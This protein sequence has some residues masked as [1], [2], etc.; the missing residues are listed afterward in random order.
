MTLVG[1]GTWEA[2]R[3]AVDCA[4]DAADLVTAGEPL[5]VRPVPAARPPRDAG[6][7]RR[8]LLPQQRRGRGRRRCAHGGA[9]AGRGGRRRRPPRQRHGGDLL[10]PRRR[11]LRLGPRRPRRRAGSRTSSG[12][13]DETG[14][15]D[16]RGRHPQPPARPR[17]PATS[18][19]STAVAELADWVA[20]AGCTALVVSLGRR[21]GGRRPGEPAAGHR[22]T[23]TATAGPLARRA[24]ACPRWWSR[25][26]ATTCRRWVAWSR[27]TSTGHAS[28]AS[29]TLTGSERTTAPGRSPEPS[30][31]CAR[32]GS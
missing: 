26:A 9:R 32:G 3:A 24:R 14:A 20:A 31:C 8:L 1:P 7:V 11:A 28:A 15:G 4:L 18:R 27:R 16:G 23:A 22:A 12:Y 25:R 6:R 19:G 30:W 5:G 2:A 17:A 13:A 10:R 29:R 21:R